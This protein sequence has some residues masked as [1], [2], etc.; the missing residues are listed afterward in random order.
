MTFLFTGSIH[1]NL[2]PM[3]Q[4]LAITLINYDADYHPILE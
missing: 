1:S 3:L 4:T 2:V